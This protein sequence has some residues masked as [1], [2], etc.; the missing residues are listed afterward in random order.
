MNNPRIP[1][2]FFLFLLLLGALQWVNVYPQLPNRVA[3]HFA[4]DGTPNGWQ[5]KQDFFLIPIFAITLCTFVSFLLPR[6]LALLPPTLIN[7]P[8]KSYWLAPERRAATIKIMNA[9]SAWFGC[10]FLFVVLYAVAQAINSNLPAHG[11]FNGRGMQFVIVGF[12]VY[13]T[14]VFAHMLRYLLRVPTSHLT[15]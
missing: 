3:C 6:M 10:G 14:L 9:H 7:L 1:A 12:C 8:N 5:S 2:L 15:A 13:S 4:A 11:Q